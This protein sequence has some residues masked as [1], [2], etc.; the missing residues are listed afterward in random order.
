M[1]DRNPKIHPDFGQLILQKE[2]S[3]FRKVPQTPGRN[4]KK[5]YLKN[6][7]KVLQDILLKI[8]FL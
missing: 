4:L 1:L 7:M 8:I 3:Y 5:Y 2:P 6:Q